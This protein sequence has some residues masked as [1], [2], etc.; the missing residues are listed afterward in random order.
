MS[1]RLCSIEFCGNHADIKYKNEW[2]CFK[3]FEDI[4]RNEGLNTKKIKNIMKLLLD[5]EVTKTK[6]KLLEI[7][8]Q[9]WL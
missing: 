2:Y 1:N 4:L 8:K 7:K 5:I 6:L 3:D 9:K